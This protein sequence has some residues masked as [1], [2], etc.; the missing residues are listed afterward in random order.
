MLLDGF[1]DSEHLA[2]AGGNSELLYRLVHAGSHFHSIDPTDIIG[3]PK[4][5][6][7]EW[8]T[9]DEIKKAREVAEGR[10]NGE[11]VAIVIDGKGGK[12]Q[13][14]GEEER[15]SSIDL[16]REFG[17]KLDETLR[18]HASFTLTL[19][20]RLCFVL[21]DS[22]LLDH[23]PESLG[24]IADAKALHAETF[25]LKDRIVKL[26]SEIIDSRARLHVCEQQRILAERTLDRAVTEHSRQLA[27][28]VTSQGLEHNT[29]GE[30]T[31]PSDSRDSSSVGDMKEL[32]LKISVLE[33]QLAES[34]GA[35]ARAEMTL[36][37][38][39]A[40]PLS[41]T[42][43]QVSDKSEFAKSLVKKNR[44][45]DF[46]ICGFIGLFLCYFSFINRKCE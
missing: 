8:S 38:R 36:T 46:F 5:N 23:L 28:G 12:V 40:R 44:F 1:G 3:L 27:N 41:Q 18:A 39:L 11:T 17:G 24:A 25:A 13:K 42:E 26:S 19:L 9:A 4:L 35:K 32:C 45:F 30:D 15:K 22:G 21:S 33:K 34:E 20:E 2:E 6:V 7:D 16:D 14:R 10:L 31:G 37:E 43:A 29:E